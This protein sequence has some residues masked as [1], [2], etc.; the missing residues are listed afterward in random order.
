M[1]A[2]AF[3]LLL[4][5]AI[6]EEERGCNVGFHYVAS[7]DC[8]DEIKEVAAYGP[9][10]AYSTVCEEGLLTCVTTSYLMTVSGCEVGVAEGFCTSND[11]ADACAAWESDIEN[12]GKTLQVCT[13]CT[14]DYCNPAE[15]EGDMRSPASS[16]RAAFVPRIIKALLTTLRLL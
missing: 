5:T 8:P 3:L 10:F 13:A 1:N 7:S 4:G 16:L 2:L 6:A 9:M 15:F 14:T 12:E 11:S